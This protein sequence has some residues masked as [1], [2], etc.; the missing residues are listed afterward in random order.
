MFVQIEL[1]NGELI[2]SD[3]FGMEYSEVTPT[4]FDAQVQGIVDTFTDWPSVGHVG[5]EINGR[6]RYFNPAHVLWAEIVY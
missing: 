4:E 3:E 1:T 6:Q 5:F 2:R